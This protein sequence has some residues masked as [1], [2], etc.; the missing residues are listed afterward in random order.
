[1][2]AIR[3]MKKWLF[4]RLGVACLLIVLLVLAL[5]V[6]F[7]W[8]LR[9]VLA[10]YG[11]GFDSYERVGYTRFALTNVR[12]Q[13]DNAHFNSKR[14]V[15][16]LPTRRL[17]RRY[18]KEPDPERFLSVTAWQLQ[19]QPGETSE[20]TGSSGSAFA[21]AD[22]INGQLPAWRSWLPTARLTDG[23]IQVGSNEVRVATAEWQRGKLTA[24]G[25][26]PKPQESFVLNGDFSGTPP[27]SVAIEAKSFA[28]SSRLQLSRTTDQ[29][30]AGGEVI[31]QSNR[32][33]F[34]AGFG[35]SSW[36]PE[37]ARLKSDSVR[38]PATLLPLS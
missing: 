26:W 12:A 33:E 10:R 28:A 35:R 15:G 6:W 17:W 22:Q 36:W 14:I 9:P 32:M 18:S 31:W 27:Y 37:Q 8:L 11:V 1:M 7:P 25:Q 4:K 23:T 29:W 3:P 24:T 2:A 5:P 21:V 38:V 34:E 19:I 20:R 16:F 30:R 13:F